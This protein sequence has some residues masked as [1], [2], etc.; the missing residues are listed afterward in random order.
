[1][2]AEKSLLRLGRLEGEVVGA[3]QFEDLRVAGLHQDMEPFG[4]G[5]ALQRDE[6]GVELQ[7]PRGGDRLSYNFV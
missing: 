5:R 1:M 4:V 2:F 3:Q 6:E 7:A